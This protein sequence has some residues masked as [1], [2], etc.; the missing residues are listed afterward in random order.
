MSARPLYS[1]RAAA[2]DVDRK[3]A[4][5]AVD[6]LAVEVIREEWLVEDRWWTERPLRRH[7]YEA[8]LADGRRAI[9]YHDLETGRWYRQGAA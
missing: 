1:P 8:V 7:Y 3:G 2:V 4:P 6:A 5:R 9:V